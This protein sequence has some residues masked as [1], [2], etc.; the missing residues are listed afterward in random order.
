MSRGENILWASK[1]LHDAQN[2][3]TERIKASIAYR[4]Q[5]KQ[6]AEETVSD[7]H[8]VLEHVYTRGP[9]VGGGMML[10]QTGKSTAN[11]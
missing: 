2:E 11:S 3:I 4:S 5:L 8:D 6:L 9:F 1:R 10:T 7:V